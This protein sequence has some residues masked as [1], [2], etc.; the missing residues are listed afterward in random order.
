[1]TTPPEKIPGHKLTEWW[2]TNGMCQNVSS[3]ARGVD[4]CC[5]VAGDFTL[6]ARVEGHEEVHNLGNHRN[7]VVLKGHDVVVDV[8]QD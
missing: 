6:S 2:L 1:M 8:G 7:L 3:S 4:Q 5:A